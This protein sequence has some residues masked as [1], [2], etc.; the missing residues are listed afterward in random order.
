MEGVT[1][2]ALHYK[3]TGITLKSGQEIRVP[4]IVDKSSISVLHYDFCTANSN[5]SLRVYFFT[6]DGSRQ[7]LL[8]ATYPKDDGVPVQG[9]VLV[10]G[11]GRL[12]LAWDNGTTWLGRTNTLSY[13][14]ILEYKKVDSRGQL[15][16][17]V[18][19]PAAATAAAGSVSTP[20][21]HSETKRGGRGN[22]TRPNSTPVGTVVLPTTAAGSGKPANHGQGHGE[23]NGA[24]SS[25]FAA[26][27]TG[28]QRAVNEALTFDQKVTAIFQFFDQDGDD[29][30]CY[31]EMDQLMRT[32]SVPPRKLEYLQWVEVCNFW[33]ANAEVGLPLRSLMSIYASSPGSI[34]E[35][36]ERFEQLVQHGS[37][38][39][40]YVP[41][42]PGWVEVDR[43]DGSSY[44]MNY[45]DM[46]KTIEARPPRKAVS[47]AAPAGAMTL[48]AP[49]AVPENGTHTETTGRTEPSFEDK[50]LL[51]FE[52]FDADGNGYLDL[53]ELNAYTRAVEG[54]RG[55]I[56]DVP[57]WIRVV[58]ALG[59]NAELGIS[60]ASFSRMHHSGGPEAAAGLNRDY[61]YVTEQHRL[62]RTRFT[63]PAHE[64][65][66]EAGQGA[67]TPARTTDSVERSDR[68]TGSSGNAGSA[69]SKPHASTAAALPR[70]ASL[71]TLSQLR[72]A[73]PWQKCQVIFA[74]FDEDGDGLLNFEE[75]QHYTAVT[76]GAGDDEEST[77]LRSTWNTLC[78][79][80]GVDPNLGFACEDL[81]KIYH[82]SVDKDIARVFPPNGHDSSG[83]GDGVHSRDLV[84]ENDMNLHAKIQRIF[85]KFD[86]D[87]DNYMNLDEMNA[88]TAITEGEQEQLTRE[89][90]EHTCRRMLINPDIGLAFNDL[91]TIYTAHLDKDFETVVSEKRRERR[92]EAAEKSRRRM[93]KQLWD[94]EQSHGIP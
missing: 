16:L 51:V 63:Q 36:Y 13:S 20:A 54:P 73:D 18:Q 81:F 72:C 48:V 57:S 84:N 93:Q 87:Q 35:E 45:A 28:G 5:A 85:E 23:D 32:I 29:V 8:P 55:Q 43:E 9:S 14:V 52:F 22:G 78:Q 94:E 58:S 68:S 1:L 11:L 3:S 10:K 61:V 70:N 15:A 26:G 88:F 66:P 62:A 71:R 44:Y 77:L 47:P 67:L 90:W 76:E 82:V 53:N 79:R 27:S 91:A 75:M 6:D 31:S 74:H 64:S 38:A 37:A 49:Q 12:E 60:L 46:S 4:I 25:N 50:C 92:R 65:F 41:C 39:I 86:A 56:L 33:A 69:P 83:H 34:D 80:R 19:K 30:L 17:P 59:E 42:P 89:E 40:Q 2:D 7:V 24:S 21:S